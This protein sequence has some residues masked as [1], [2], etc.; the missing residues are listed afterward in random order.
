VAV[1]GVVVAGVGFGVFDSAPE[2]GTLGFASTGSASASRGPAT[3]PTV[4]ASP[5]PGKN[6]AKAATA[7]PSAKAAVQSARITALATR[8]PLVSA[9][10]SAPATQSARL[11]PIGS[12][13]LDQTSSTTAVDAA[14][15]HNGVA[16]NVSWTGS[17]AEFNGTDSQI[18][19]PDQVVDTA[20]GASFTIAAWV[21]LSSDSTF[22]TAVSQDSPVNSG[23]YLEYAQTDNRWAFARRSADTSSAG[24]DRAESLAPPAL[25]TWT[26]LI[27]V[28][29]ASGDELQLYVD[30]QIQGTAS[31]PT[32]FASAGNLIIGRSVASGGD[33]AYFPGQIKDVQVFNRALTPA[34]VQALTEYL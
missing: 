20:P 27:G 17:A 30:G 8:M 1:T 24:A 33:S 11:E 4:G 10:T 16:E 5:S 15:D 6:P 3:S 22:A 31:D 23:F 21:D 28:F 14:G 25:G 32:P 7:R 34:Q 19:V 29:D 26:S 9:P 12:W 18:E 13:P 2:R